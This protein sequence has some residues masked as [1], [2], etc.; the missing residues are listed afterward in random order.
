MM[1]LKIVCG[2]LIVPLINAFI[3]GQSKGIVQINSS[4]SVHFIVTDPQGRRTGADPRGTSKPWIGQEFNE[5]PDAN[6]STSGVGDSPIDDEPRDEDLSHEFLY[7]LRSPENDGVYLIECIGLE[8]KKFSLYIDLTS[9]NPTLMQPFSTRFRDLLDSNQAIT[10][11]IEYH[12]Q[13][14]GPI[15]FDK[16]VSSSTLRQDLGNSYKLKLLGDK[17]L[18]KD[19]SHRLDKFKKDLARKDSSDARDEL[20]KFGE[21]I[22]EVRKETVK[23]EQRKQ[24]PPKHFITA[25]AYQI[26]EEDVNALLKQLP[27]KKKGNKDKD[28]DR[29]DDD[30]EG[31]RDGE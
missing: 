1:K 11:R 25:D 4:I 26:L 31:H 2:F 16:I 6:Y 20:K 19:L 8:L 3:Y 13:P 12:G 23:R 24:K 27:M 10:Y 5:I 18:Y 9:D 29:K 17:E 22:E 30:R 7:T 15:K 28:D 14:E 21:K